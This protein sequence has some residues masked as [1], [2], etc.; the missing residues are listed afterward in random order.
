M[1]PHLAA[2]LAGTTIDVD[3]LVDALRADGRSARWIVE[4]AG[5]VL[6]PLNE[7]ELMVDLMVAARRCRSSSSRASTLG[8][9]NHTLLTLEALRRAFAARSPAS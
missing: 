2:R 8:T 1:S 4:G 7:R 9:I 5:G 6:V 3:A